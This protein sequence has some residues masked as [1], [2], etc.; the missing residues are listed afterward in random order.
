MRVTDTEGAAEKTLLE[1][2][3]LVERA[4][5]RAIVQ[6]WAATEKEVDVLRWWLT[7]LADGGVKDAEAQK[8]WLYQAMRKHRA[9]PAWDNANKPPKID[10]QMQER[11]HYKGYVDDRV[12]FVIEPHHIYA[13]VLILRDTTKRT[14]DE[15]DNTADGKLLAGRILREEMKEEPK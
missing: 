2:L 15:I 4:D 6:K 7:I 5:R 11:R 10:W 1:L 8:A 13:S 12:R 14:T 3:P 9:D